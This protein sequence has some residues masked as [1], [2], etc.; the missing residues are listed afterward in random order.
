MEINSKYKALFN[1]TT[2][3]TM[4]T[5]GRASG[6]SHVAPIAVAH[7]VR[8]PQKQTCLFSRYTMEAAYDSIIP[9]F[10]S[11][12]S[13]LGYN[14]YFTPAKNNLNCVN[15]NK[16]LFRGLKTSSGNQTAKLKS[17]EGLNIFVLDEGEEWNDEAAFDTIEGS[18]REK[19]VLNW[20]LIIMNPSHV[21]HWI[22]KKFFKP[23]NI[24]DEFNG[25]VDNVQYIH[26]TYLDNIENLSPD[27]LEMINR[28]KERNYP[29][30]KHLYLG[31]W[32]KD[33]EGALWRAKTIEDNRTYE[34]PQLAKIVVSVDPAT[35]ATMDSDETGIT[36]VGKGFDGR[37]YLLADKSG[38]YTPKQWAQ[39]S[40]SLFNYWNADCIVAE[41]NQGG[42]MVKHTIKTEAENAPVK[43]VHAS[44]GKILRAEPISALYEDGKMSH[45][46]IFADA[47]EEMTTYTGDKSE[48]SPNR[49]D[50]I[51]HGFTCLFPVRESSAGIHW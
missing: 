11:R 3:I 33:K 30:Y 1:P 5:G 35:T 13:D 32:Q 49:L 36:V 19:N 42:D 48:K 7:Q 41:K 26:T 31:H 14:N 10:N 29:K 15:E 2:R 38:I 46:G 27:Y 16:I 34:V 20:I 25:I 4:L 22:Y 43:L 44:K 21:N 12:I 23:H 8:K 47:E 45:V 37:G 9:E 18:I 50:A 39:V 6:K 17:I 28:M 24:P 40:V 51:V